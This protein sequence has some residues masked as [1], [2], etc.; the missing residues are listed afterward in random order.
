MSA[1]DNLTRYLTGKPASHGKGA[2]GTLI[3]LLG[4]AEEQ[5]AARLAAENIWQEPETIGLEV[6]TPTKGRPFDDDTWTY[7]LQK[8]NENA[9]TPRVRVVGNYQPNQGD[10]VEFTVEWTGEGYDYSHPELAARMGY[11]DEIH[12]LAKGVAQAVS[13]GAENPH[14]RNF[15]DRIDASRSGSKTHQ[16]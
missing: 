7:S 6:N 3:A 4:T 15:A 16:R 1:A 5:E 11:K 13:H 9:P 12:R 8:T 2:A 10:A 14:E